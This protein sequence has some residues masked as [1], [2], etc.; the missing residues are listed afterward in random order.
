MRQHDT[1]A[2]TGGDR[3]RG[4]CHAALGQRA[5][6]HAVEARCFLQALVDA[7]LM[8]APRDL[9]PVQERAIDPGRQEEQKRKHLQHA[10]SIEAV[11]VGSEYPLVPSSTHLLVDRCTLDWRLWTRRSPGSACP[12]RIPR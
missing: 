12:F 11:Y 8:N 10:R 1:G 9:H 6:H 4:L 2:I 3:P 7:S 5:A